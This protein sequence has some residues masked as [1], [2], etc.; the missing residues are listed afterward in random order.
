MSA[1]RDLDALFPP[2]QDA[3]GFAKQFRLLR[4][5]GR[6][7]LAL[8]AGAREAGLALDL[9][10]AQ[11]PA[12]RIAKAGLQ[13]LCR[14]G[15]PPPLPS[16]ERRFSCADPFTD[17]LCSLAPSLPTGAGSLGVFAGNPGAVGRRW[18]VLLFDAGE[19]VVAVKAGA[20]EPA[21]ALVAAEMAF[22]D[23]ARLP[24]IA[25]PRAECASGRVVAF[26]M[27]FL[28]GASPR[29]ASPPAIHRVLRPWIR[30]NQHLPLASIPA[31][32]R[33]AAAGGGVGALADV[34]V[35][36]V[37]M[38]GDFAPWNVKVEAGVWQVF[39]WERGELCGVPGWDWFHF[40][41]Q[42]AM[43][44]ARVDPPVIAELLE[45]LFETEEFRDYARASQIAGHERGL[46]LGYVAYCALVQRQTEGAEAIEALR[47][48][49]NERWKRA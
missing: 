25:A 44:V 11:R 34:Q 9:Y 2:T 28:R 8:P 7:L 4:R 42:P 13:S 22:L 24:G 20:D 38:H 45:A 40:T 17:F 18:L 27:D 36:P 31:W 35:C 43:L 41:I 46:A 3:G 21:R 6:L 37:V 1:A 29:S 16:L 12:A 33:L 47:Q 23:Q 5:G 14:L 39:D 48:H 32:A 26:A 49:L 15:L 30:Q 10:A 19:P